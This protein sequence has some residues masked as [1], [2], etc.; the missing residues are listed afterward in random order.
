MFLPF[1]DFM[2]GEAIEEVFV[3][4]ALKIYLKLKSSSSPYS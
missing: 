2:V 1:F 3:L 4:K